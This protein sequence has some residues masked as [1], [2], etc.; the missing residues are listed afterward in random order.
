M[1]RLRSSAVLFG[2]LLLSLAACGSD[3]SD[4]GSTSPATEA[5]STTVTPSGS[6]TIPTTAATS[7]DTS[8]DLGT[9]S[10]EAANGTVTLPDKPVRIVSLSPSQTETLFAI[11][12]GDQVIA[13]DDQSNY[14]P[15]VEAV[16]S[17]LSGYTPNVEAIAGY[18]PDLVVIADDFNGLAPQLEALDIPV[19]SG[20]AAMSLEDAYAQIEQL[21]VLT[22]HVGEAAEVVATM[23]SEIEAITADVPAQEAPLTYYHEID[24][25][26]FSVT[27]DTFIGQ[28]YELA[29]LRN[30][31]DGVEAGNAYPQLNNEFIITAD[32]QLIFLADAKC[33][34]ESAATVAA[35]DG[36]GDITA[37]KNG[38]VIELDDD[39]ASR[40]GPRIPEFLATVVN[41]AKAAE[42]TVTTG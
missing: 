25:T 36:W 5:A 19:W 13:V 28:I 37:V 34:Q 31:A 32:P 2:A 16:K 9:F 27:S 18:N 14:P 20:P 1:S 7:A 33:C 4:S 30:I 22:G 8:A 29:G 41:A 21:G 17:T 12:A 24:N 6:E 35:R 38:S 26:L 40:W 3:E 10:V 39:L 23:Q 15:E 11:G 42:A